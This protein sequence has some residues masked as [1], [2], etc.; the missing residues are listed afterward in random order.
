VSYSLVPASGDSQLKLK[1]S[2]HAFGA[3]PVAHDPPVYPA[4][5]IGRMLP[6]VTIRAKAI[7]DETG[8]VTEVRDLDDSQT[9]EHKAFFKAC[10]QTMTH[11]TYTPMTVVEEFDDG[12]GNISQVRKDSPFSLD[13]AFRF[14]LVD[15]KPTV[16]AHQ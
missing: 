8:S 14:E 7:I 4:E 12:R 11:W 13:Y 5:L 1:R 2:E 6:L 15:G 16:T 9:P 3:Q 10:Q